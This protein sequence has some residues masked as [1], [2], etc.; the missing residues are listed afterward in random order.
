MGLNKFCHRFVSLF[1]LLSGILEA[2][3]SAAADREEEAATAIFKSLIDIGR[4]KHTLVLDTCHSFLV[5]HSKVIC[6][7]HCTL[8]EAFLYMFVYTALHGKSDKVWL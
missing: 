3:V 7:Y 5:K 8:I 4:K 6:Y 1:F 2:L